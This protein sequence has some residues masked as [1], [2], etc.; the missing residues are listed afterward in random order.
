MNAYGTIS[1]GV[2][3]ALFM[4]SVAVLNDSQIE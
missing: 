2:A 1:T 4:P 3:R